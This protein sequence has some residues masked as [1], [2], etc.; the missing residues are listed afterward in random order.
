MN[1]VPTA[2][3]RMVGRQGLVAQKNAPTLLFGAGVIG[4]IGSTVLACRATLKAEEKLHQIQVDLHK[5]NTD[6]RE[7]AEDPQNPKYDEHEYKK[8]LALIY[9]RAAVDFGKLYGPSL[10][11]GAASIACLTKSHNILNDRVTAVS[12]AYA[13]VDS[14]FTRYR[15]RVAAKYGEEEDR[16]LLYGVEEVD[17]IEEETGKITQVQRVGPDG[18]SQYARFFDKMSANWNTDAEVNLLFLRSQQNYFNDLLVTRGHVFLNEVYDAL[19]LDHTEAGAV[20]GWVVAKNHGGDNY[21]DFGI[22]EGQSQAAR[23]FVNGREGAILLD[24]NVDGIIFDKIGTP[25]GDR[26]WQS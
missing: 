9:G 23:D 20:V 1:F 4:M 8:D 24:F 13:A 18:H 26:K 12:A 11:L 7:I 16:N 2:I 17:L 21:I 6:M 15:E 14:A 25:R 19:D 3:S 22:W 5:T 10:I